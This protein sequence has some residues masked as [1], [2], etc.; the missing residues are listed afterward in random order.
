MVASIKLWSLSSQ[1]CLHTFTHHT[2]SVWSLFSSHPSLEVFY[3][4]DRSGLVCK[5]DVEGCADVSE[6]E[7]ILLC[8][9]SG[10]DRP[11]TSGSGSEGINRIVAMDDNLLW[12]ASGSSS[13]KR[14]RVPARRALRATALSAEGAVDGPVSSPPP[15]ES[16]PRSKS[17]PRSPSISQTNSR[18]SSPPASRS[19][20][21]SMSQSSLS[22]NNNS[23]ATATGDP[24]LEL[25]PEREGEE[26]W[27]GIP[28]ESLVRLTSPNDASGFGMGG[29]ALRG[30]DAEIATLYSAAS[31]R[32]VPR[33]VRSPVQTMFGQPQPLRSASPFRSDTM[34]SQ[35]D[36]RLPNEDGQTVHAP[37]PRSRAAY[38]IREV[39]ADAVPLRLEADEVIEGEHGL[40]RC[41]MLNDRMHALTVDTA[42]EVAVW[43]VVRGVCLGRYAGADV[44]A[45]SFCGSERSGGSVKSVSGNGAGTGTGN[46]GGN[47]NGHGGEGREEAGTQRSPREALETVRERI[48]G[49]AVV[50][51]WAALETKTGVLTVHVNER[52]FE[53]EVYADEA[54]YGHERVNEEV[55]CELYARDLWRED[56][57]ADLAYSQHWEMGPAE[58][59]LWLHPRR[60]AAGGATRQRTR[61]ARF[62]PAPNATRER[63]RPHRPQQCGFACEEPCVIGRLRAQCVVRYC[64][65]SKPHRHHPLPH[66]A[67]C[68]VSSDLCG[69]PFVA[70][71]DAD[72]PAAWRAPRFRFG[73]HP[74]VT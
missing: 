53:A 66:H 8:Q 60:T 68:G 15:L 38:E 65:P 49:E 63:P 47:G 46:G 19:P 12:T 55:R 61:R 33:M 2:E 74:P 28:F 34:R 13:V 43:D 54:G 17:V 23:T 9:D 39:A 21:A 10:S 40:V 71:H 69:T 50:P 52:C 57:E 31:V 16:P 48:E 7:C 11:G 44:A 64:G 24:E 32:S 1:R 25:D 22:H 20:R 14:W 26:T 45:A 42:G 5:V 30:P 51:A 56:V 67:P 27:Y 18:S 6:G 70:P 3:S 37:P 62:V 58:F 72:D 73:H 36:P 59:V 35:P 4:G 41:V 29:P